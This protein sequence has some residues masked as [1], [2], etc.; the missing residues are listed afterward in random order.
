MAAKKKRTKEDEER[1]AAEKLA[2]PLR[3]RLMRGMSHPLRYKLLTHLNDRE[4]SPKELS[5]HLAEGLSQVSYHVKVLKDYGLI[6][7]TRTEPAR[8]ATQHFYKA[9]TRTIIGMKVA[10][11]IPRD[12]R[13]EL[14]GGV[15]DE[16]N[17]DVNE[18]YETGL[19]DSRNHYHVARIPMIFDEQACEDGHVRG[20]DYID[21]MLKI[22][23]EAATRLGESDD[24][25]PIGVTAVLLVFPSA[26]AEREKGSGSKQ[27]PKA[28]K[29][30]RKSRKQKNN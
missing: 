6:E 21:D 16:V 2:L 8:G 1:I 28:K 20:D 12:S 10:S 3:E 29:Q 23:G 11:E 4:W 9:T 30:P 25:K 27:P 18:S 17:E 5:D 7:L 26:Q 14:I 13:R 15:L 22:A 19:Y 24:P